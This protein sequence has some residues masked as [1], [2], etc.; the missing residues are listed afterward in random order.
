M[1]SGLKIAFGTTGLLAIA[2]LL[3]RGSRSAPPTGVRP[4]LAQAR[5]HDAASAR[6]FIRELVKRDLDFHFED[7]VDDLPMFSAAEVPVVKRL[8]DDLYRHL[9]DPF[10]PLMDEHRRQREGSPSKQPG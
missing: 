10:V 8:V 4:F 9:D 2:G 5:I 7:P 6:R 3:R 1:S